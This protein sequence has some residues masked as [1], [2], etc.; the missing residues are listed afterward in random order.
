M[1]SKFHKGPNWQEIFCGE[2]WKHYA[3]W[4]IVL[5]LG[6][7]TVKDVAELC[8]QYVEDPSQSDFTVVFNESMTMPNITF[9][10]GRTQAMSH[11]VINTTEVESGDWDTII[12][13]RLTNLSDHSSFLEQPWDYRMIMEAYECI[14]SL[15]SLE[16]ETT[17]AG[18]VHSIERLRTSPQLAGKRDL[19]KKWLEAITVR[20]I[21]FGEFVQK[22]GVELLKR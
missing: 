19:I 14:S 5:F 4:F 13:D 12:D 16:R 6:M 2:V 15:Y 8:I 21:T 3:F 22:T 7:L 20:S 9:C 18:L 17:L 1:H 11:F 10:M